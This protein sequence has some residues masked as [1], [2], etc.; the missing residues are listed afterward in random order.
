MTQVHAIRDFL[1]IASYN[2][3]QVLKNEGKQIALVASLKLVHEPV[4]N[5]A[6]RSM[7]RPYGLEEVRYKQM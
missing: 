4:I 1:D 2:L 5:L 3:D 7:L 6:H